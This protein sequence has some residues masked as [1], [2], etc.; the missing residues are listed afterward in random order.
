MKSQLTESFLRLFGSLPE[1]VRVKARRAYRLWS[2]DPSHP[3]LRFKRIHGGE[4]V[5]S[6]RIGRG[7]R[8][9]GLL[10]G[11]VVTWF[12]VGSHA[13]YDKLVGS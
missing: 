11:D 6:V 7:W 9:L 13:D 5:Y 10:E 12:W 8:A 2:N 3:S 4:P 1:D